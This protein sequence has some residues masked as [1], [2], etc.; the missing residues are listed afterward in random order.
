MTK[1]NPKVTVVMSSY[2][3]KDYIKEAIE[4]ILNQTYQNFE[5]IIIDDCSQKKLKM[6]LNNMPKTM[7]E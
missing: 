4:S 1:N 2:N 7:K 3:R 6:S 5:F